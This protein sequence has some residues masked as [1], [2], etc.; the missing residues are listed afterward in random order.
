[1]SHTVLFVDDE[2]NVLAG[3][4]RLLRKESYEILTAATA[5]EA[6]ELLEENSVDLI[7]SDEEMPG[8]SGTEFLARVARDHPDVERRKCF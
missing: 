8:M 6:A 3:L 4:T 7:V 2:P 1:M 5:E